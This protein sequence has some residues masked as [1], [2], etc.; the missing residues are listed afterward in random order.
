MR[1]LFIHS[2]PYLPQNLGGLE[3]TTDDLCRELAALGHQGAVMC[4]I[5]RADLLWVRNRL[6]SRLTGRLYPRDS[7]A[8]VPVYRGHLEREGLPQVIEDFRPDALVVAGGSEASF[9]LAPVCVRTGLPSF[10]YFHELRG[11]RRNPGLKLPPELGLF[12]NSQ[13]TARAVREVTGR[14]SVV[15]PPLVDRSAYQ[16]VSSRRF[17]TMVNPRK[18]K[19]GETAFALVK[20][21]SDIPFLFVEAWQG[22]DEFVTALRAAARSTPNLTW[23]APTTDMRRVYADTAIVL[24]PSDWE[25]TWGRVATEAHASG[26]PVLARA[27][28]GLPESVG[29]GGILIDARAPLED[30]VRALRSMWDDSAFYDNLVTRAREF[31][32]RAQ[33]QPRQLAQDF[34]EGLRA[35][36]APRPSTGSRP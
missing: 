32:A 14:D 27:V 4:S 34:I 33:A 11:L 26:I 10:L 31:S 17:V 1:V 3:T 16:T 8:G 7:Y 9:E 19:G 24:V 22:D 28:A 23:R 13:Y 35:G 21:C 15:V 29:P 20:A 2:R 30:W 5:G 25:E 12:T 6:T 18:V 36:A